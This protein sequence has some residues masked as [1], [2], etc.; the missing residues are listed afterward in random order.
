MN[1]ETLSKVSSLTEREREI[2]ELCC[3]IKSSKGVAAELGISARTVDTHKTNIFKKL[4][5]KS[6]FELM[7]LLMEMK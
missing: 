3:R 7:C 6:T 4:G 5:I 2:A 1:K